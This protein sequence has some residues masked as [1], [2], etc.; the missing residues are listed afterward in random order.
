MKASHIIITLLIIIGGINWGLWGFFQF[1]LVAE[2][3]GGSSS[4]LSRFVYSI[5]G[6]A[7]VYQLVT[8]KLVPSRITVQNTSTKH[9]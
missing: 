6:I 9:S 7:A 4:T 2:L 5:V 1:D 3:F 8:L